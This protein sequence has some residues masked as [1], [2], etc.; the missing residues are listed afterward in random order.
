MTDSN[1][2]D[3]KKVLSLSGKGKLE[4]KNK[5][6]A[7]SSVRQSFSHGRS[8]TVTVEVKRKRT[9]EKGAAPGVADGGACRASCRRG[10]APEGVGRWP[11]SA[12]QPAVRQL[13]KEERDF[14]LKALQDAIR[15]DEERR[16]MEA[17]LAQAVVVEEPPTV[18]EAP[19]LE[20]DTETLRQ[21]E[22]E[23]L[24]R[25][26]DEER[27]IAEEAERE[28]QEEEAKRKEA[29]AARRP[30]PP[31][32]RAPARADG[33]AP[34]SRSGDDDR[35]SSGR[36]PAPRVLPPPPLPKPRSASRPRLSPAPT[37]TRTIV[38]A[39]RP[40]RVLAPPRLRPRLRQPPRARPATAAVAAPR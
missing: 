38:A 32:G 9:I 15:S 4:L 30:A 26:Q 27:A 40:L 7:D 24:K 36:G 13:T 1:D 20:L 33:E 19:E 25:I 23:E 2:Q 37:R 5:P 12:R 31:A 16:Q 34:A 14:R 17:E 28:R 29:E 8:K 21:R 11:W 3:R 6:A 22:I 18:E 35:R 10:P 39:A